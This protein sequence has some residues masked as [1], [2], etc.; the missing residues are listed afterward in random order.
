MS[1][2]KTPE[3]AW[4]PF[5]EAREFVRGLGLKSRSDWREYCESGEKPE[6]IPASPRSVYGEFTGWGD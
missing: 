6:N 1:S 3:N 4:K 5:G 2:K